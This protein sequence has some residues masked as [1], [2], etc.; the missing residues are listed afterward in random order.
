[1]GAVDCL[2]FSLREKPW[3]NIPASDR[4]FWG[5]FCFWRKPVPPSN[6]EQGEDEKRNSSVGTDPN[7]AAVRSPLQV[8]EPFQL[9]RLAQFWLSKSSDQQKAAESESSQRTYYG[10]AG[11][12]NARM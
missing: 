5:S 10:R 6:I 11:R 3:R 8:P 7:S 2:I 1:M 12:W 4:T 9:P